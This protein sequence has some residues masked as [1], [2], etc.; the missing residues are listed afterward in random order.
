MAHAV[1]IEKKRNYLVARNRET[2][3]FII[4]ENLSP[5]IFV[6]V[7]IT[8]LLKGVADNFRIVETSLLN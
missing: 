2:V 7:L 1:V 5:A 8:K 6:V 3:N 4:N